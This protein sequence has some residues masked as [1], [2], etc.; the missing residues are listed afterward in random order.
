MLSLWDFYF[1]LRWLSRGKYDCKWI[2]L[3]RC[4]DCSDIN[5]CP[6]SLKGVNMSVCYRCGKEKDDIE[7]LNFDNCTY[8]LCQRCIETLH[9]R[10]D[11][12]MAGGWKTFTSWLFREKWVY[13]VKSSYILRKNRYFTEWWKEKKWLKKNSK[14]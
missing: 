4:I 1:F 2:I 12:F 10:F 8:R 14:I 3:S 13:L 9:R 6:F 7:S 11:L 5:L